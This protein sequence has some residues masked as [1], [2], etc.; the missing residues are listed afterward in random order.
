MTL[1]SIINLKRDLGDAYLTALEK[2]GII[3]ISPIDASHPIE[4]L[5]WVNVKMN[6]R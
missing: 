6:H 1:Q 5:Q 4:A 3:Q 2:Y